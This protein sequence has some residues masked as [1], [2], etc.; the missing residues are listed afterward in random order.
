MSG[1][2]LATNRQIKK[3]ISHRWKRYFIDFTLTKKYHPSIL[4]Y[5]SNWQTPF[6]F[7]FFYRTMV[8]A[9]PG[10]YLFYVKP[11]PQ[12]Y[13]EQSFIMYVGYSMNLYKRYGDYLGTYKNSDEP[14]YY[15]RRV[16]LN[17]WEDCLYYTFI[18][19][20]NKTEK[21]IKEIEDKIIDSLVPCINRDF[22]NAVIKQQVRINRI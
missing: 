18:E 9:S 11:N 19:L 17:V 22:A 2:T 15:E 13:I 8:P 6:L 10:I 14:N 16:M 20:K 5:L 3:D 7:F 1:F 12:I 4:S 21:E